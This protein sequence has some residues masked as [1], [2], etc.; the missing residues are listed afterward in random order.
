MANPEKHEEISNRLSEKEV[1]ALIAEFGLEEDDN[2]V[3]LRYTDKDGSE[4]KVYWAKLR[5]NVGVD[6]KTQQPVGLKEDI[7]R[8]KKELGL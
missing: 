4:R 6:P 5:G 2:N 1:A 3:F 8:T 7:V